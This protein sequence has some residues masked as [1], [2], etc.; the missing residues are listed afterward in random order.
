[1]TEIEKILSENLKEA[2][3]QFQ[4]YLLWGIGSSL[5]FLILSITSYGSETITIPLPGFFASVNITFAKIIALAIAW[6]A[7]ALATYQHELAVRIAVKLQ[8]NMNLLHALL[9]FPSI[10]TEY[11]PGVRFIAVSIPGI[12]ILIGS[13]YNRGE[14]QLE[15][16]QFILLTLFLLTPYMVL[17]F[18]LTVL[19]LPMEKPTRTKERSNDK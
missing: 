12:F 9:T 17:M 10:A 1:M 16:F 13:V 2:L 18:M 5:S 4:T 14:V 7:G 3:R 19:S 15:I 11:Y 8:K 6:I